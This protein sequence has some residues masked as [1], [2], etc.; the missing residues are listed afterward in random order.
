M[1]IV[2]SFNKPFYLFSVAIPKGTNVISV[3]FS[4]QWLGL[5]LLD[6]FVSV[7]AMKILANDTA[8]FVPLAVP[9][10]SM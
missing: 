1:E 2:S 6:Y 4:F 10:V 9:C 7:S 3:T 5:A 8:I